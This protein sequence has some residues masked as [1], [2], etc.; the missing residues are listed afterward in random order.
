VVYVT[1]IVVEETVRVGVTV[2][3]GIVVV[4]GSVVR[5]S[6]VG[7][8]VS[9]WVMGTS[10]SPAVGRGVGIRVVVTISVVPIFSR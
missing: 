9:R 2:V 3:R 7:G 6:V 1:G 10:T 5:G 8:G 4:T